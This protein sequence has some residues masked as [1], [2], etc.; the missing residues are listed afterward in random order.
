MLQKTINHL[1]ALDP[2]LDLTS[3]ED[4]LF[5][6]QVTDWPITLYLK[7]KNQQVQ[8]LFKTH[9]QPDTT[10]KGKAFNLSKMGKAPLDITG[11]IHA[12]QALQKILQQLDID[13]EE[14]LSQL[15]G[16]SLAYSMA[17]PVKTAVDTLKTTKR[18]AKNDLKNYLINEAKLVPSRPETDIFY[19]KINALRLDLD[20]LSAK[21]VENTD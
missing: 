12:G 13:W 17:K 15:V 14:G 16:D 9:Y 2:D 1:L 8:I 18:S 7:V 3:I 10:I 5:L 11:D 6:L 4:K 19:Q 21:I 20:R